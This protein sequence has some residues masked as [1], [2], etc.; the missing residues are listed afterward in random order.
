M[1]SSLEEIH[2][3][4]SI[5]A[6]ASSLGVG[7]RH[8]LAWIRRAESLVGQALV[9]RH[10]GGSTGSGASLT[11]KAQRV[12]RAYRRV[13]ASIHRLVERAEREILDS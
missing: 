12:T 8:A 10:A 2:T 1:R 9:E 6:A 3:R 13:N 11:E 5:R 7:Y 4:G